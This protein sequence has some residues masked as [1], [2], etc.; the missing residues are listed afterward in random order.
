[1]TTCFPSARSL[2]RSSGSAIGLKP[3]SMSRKPCAARCGH[4]LN[5]AMVISMTLT[6]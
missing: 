1:M 4:V 5:S 2:W 3:S 6:P